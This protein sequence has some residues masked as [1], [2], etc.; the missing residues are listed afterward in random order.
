[1]RAIVI[2]SITDVQILH[3]ITV[4]NSSFVIHKAL[5]GRHDINVSS[6][7]DSYMR[8][9]LLKWSTGCFFF[10]IFLFFY[11][12]QFELDILHYNIILCRTIDIIWY[13][14]IIINVSKKQSHKEYDFTF[15]GIYTLLQNYPQCNHVHTAYI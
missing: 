15:I 13:F 14:L 5:R 4:L 12:K 3:H 9:W 10:F 6:I 8:K 11:D 1:M 7:R 2:Y